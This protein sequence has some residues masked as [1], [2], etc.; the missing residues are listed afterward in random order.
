[1]N[2]D[3][4]IKE[5]KHRLYAFR[6]GIVADCLRRS[7]VPYRVIFGV[8]LPQLSEI[9]ASIKPSAEIAGKLWDT[10]STRECMLLAPMIFPPEEMDIDTA[11]RWIKAVTTTEIADVLCL[12]LLK[13]LDHAPALADEFMVSDRALDRYTALRL[14]FNLLPARLAE[15]K[16]YAQAEM[17]RDDSV[18]YP[19][20]RALIEEISFLE[21]G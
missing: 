7:G 4:C 14:L 12:K 5:I 9:A 17:S 18:T 2:A 20:A 16:A 21:E 8:N 13:H 6:N 10:A 11:R 1:M 19:I 15:T 3:D